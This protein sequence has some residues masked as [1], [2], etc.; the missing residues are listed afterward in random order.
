[1]NE[2]RKIEQLTRTE[3]SPREILPPSSVE[4]VGGEPS[5]NESVTPVPSVDK[6]AVSQSPSPVL[7]EVTPI[8]SGYPLTSNTTEE[9]GQSSIARKAL[10]Q[11]IRNELPTN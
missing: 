8:S 6:D 1:M 7:E 11:K 4:E 9:S 5:L 10:S 2:S 3:S